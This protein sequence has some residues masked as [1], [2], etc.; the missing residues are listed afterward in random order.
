MLVDKVGHERAAQLFPLAIN[1]DDPRDDK[2]KPKAA[3]PAI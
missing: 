2:E 3:V 1:P